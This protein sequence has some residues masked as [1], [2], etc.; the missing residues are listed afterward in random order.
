[1]NIT[2]YDFADMIHDVL[3]S[4]PIL[5]LMSKEEWRECDDQVRK[6]IR[7]HLMPE[8]ESWWKWA[9]GQCTTHRE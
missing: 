5:K 7:Q 8:I 2:E 4:D 1:M 6:V 9:V 3:E